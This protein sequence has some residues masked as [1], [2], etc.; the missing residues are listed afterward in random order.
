M[1]FGAAVG[2][3]GS[4]W[5]SSR[6]G[7]KEPDGRCHPVRYRF[8]VVGD[9][10]KPGNADCRTRG[11][12]PCAVA[13]YTAPLYLGN[14]TREDPRQYDFLYQ[15]M[16]TIGI[17]GAYLSDTAFSASGDWRWMLGIITIPAV[18]LLVGVV[19]LP[20]SPRWLAAKGD[21]RDAQRVLDRL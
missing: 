3:V 5:M 21:F 19:F 12:R 1:M 11:A 2:A 16:I 4:G 8:T 15:L 9:G 17:L 7:R 6:L 10:A 13:S 20:N 14:R 18:L